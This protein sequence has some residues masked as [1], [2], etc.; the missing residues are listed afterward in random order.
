MEYQR[1]EAMGSKGRRVFS[2]VG[3]VKQGH[4]ERLNDCVWGA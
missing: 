3:E 2:V 4:E 1:L